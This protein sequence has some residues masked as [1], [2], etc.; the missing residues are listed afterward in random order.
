MVGF[1]VS[2]VTENSSMYRRS[3]PS[4]N[5]PRVMLSSQMLWPRS[6]R[7]CVARMAVLPSGRLFVRPVHDGVAL[8]LRRPGLTFDLRGRG[9]RPPGLGG[10]LVERSLDVR[11]LVGVGVVGHG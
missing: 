4:P 2:P 1:D 8:V 3:V 6:C 11:D 9:V 5:M 10:H 7:C